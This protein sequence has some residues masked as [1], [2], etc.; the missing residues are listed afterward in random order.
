MLGN[1]TSTSYMLYIFNNELCK[2]D[3]D[4]FFKKT[5]P[6]MVEM[7]LNLPKIVTHAVS[8]LKRQ[9]NYSITM[10][11]YQ[12]VCLLIHAFFLHLS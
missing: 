2:S 3:T 7:A 1:G 4:M 12:V 11:Q 8:L 6:G 5:L 9:Q 10:S